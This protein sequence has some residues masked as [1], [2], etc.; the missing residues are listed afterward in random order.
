MRRSITVESA[1]SRPPGGPFQAPARRRST[2]PRASALCGASQ[3]S[4]S[5]PRAS[6]QPSSARARTRAGRDRGHA[7]VNG[8]RL[9]EERQALA[10]QA[11]R[12]AAVA[13]DDHPRRVL[14][15]RLRGRR[16]RR[17]RWQRRDGP[18]RASRPTTAGRPAGTAASRRRRCP[19]PRRLLASVPNAVPA[20][21]RSGSNGN[22]RRRCG[23]LTRLRGVRLAVPGG[24]GTR[25]AVETVARTCSSKVVRV[26]AG[27][28]KGER[29]EHES[30]RHDGDEE[31][32]DVGR[33]DVPAAVHKRPRAGGALEREARA[34]RRADADLREMP[35]RANELDEPVR[36]RCRSMYTSFGRGPDLEQLV[37]RQTTGSSDS[38]G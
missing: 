35:R 10:G 36:A 27:V 4:S 5:T 38:S 21:G 3:S 14:G 17:V 6:H 12:R 28:G 11:H 8:R 19:D 31:A 24:L 37:A 23:E 20:N 7:L 34:N 1:R 2:T 22:A 16:T 18:T 30:V 26:H 32:L 25:D 9:R 33:L 15:V 29:L 13:D